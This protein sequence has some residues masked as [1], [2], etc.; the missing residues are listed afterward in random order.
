MLHSS[1]RPHS[2][3]PVHQRQPHTDGKPSP[4]FLLLFDLILTLCAST[5]RWQTK[6]A[7]QR[8][9]TT[10][11]LNPNEVVVVDDEDEDTLTLAIRDLLSPVDTGDSKHV[12]SCWW[13]KRSERALGHLGCGLSSYE[14]D[15]FE[16]PPAK[17]DQSSPELCFHL[18]G[19]RRVRY[20]PCCYDARLLS[21][22]DGNSQG[23]PLGRG[24]APVFA[25][26]VR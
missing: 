15:D 21:L 12:V 13:W 6:P 7:T 25:R 24:T 14:P 16:R 8:E 10:D 3:Q 2:K 1:W 20:N 18:L 19:S 22:S 4:S 23:R 17:A 9:T 26:E 5:L 11:Q